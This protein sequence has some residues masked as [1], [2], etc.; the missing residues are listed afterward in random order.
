MTSVGVRYAYI[1]LS[2]LHNALKAH[3]HL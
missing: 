1:V 3:T 2:N